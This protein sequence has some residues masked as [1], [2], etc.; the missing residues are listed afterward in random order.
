MWGGGGRLRPVSMWTRRTGEPMGWRRRECKG[1]PRPKLSA[2]LPHHLSPLSPCAS[3]FRLLPS[4]LKMLDPL[5]VASRS[6]GCACEE[7]I[8][9]PAGA[10]AV[11]FRF[12]A[13]VRRVVSCG[14][15]RCGGQASRWCP[16]CMGACMDDACRV[17]PPHSH[18]STHA[19]ESHGT[20]F[21]TMHYLPEAPAARTRARSSARVGRRGVMVLFS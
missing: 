19:H 3:P 2:P 17:H 12:L 11:P 14:V 7:V 8:C 9:W 20:A 16:T 6:T 18:A 10:P 13:V 21:F 4:P 5:G 15:V 1:I